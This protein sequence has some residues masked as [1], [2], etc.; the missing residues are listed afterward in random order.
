MGKTNFSNKVHIVHDGDYLK[1]SLPKATNTPPPPK[2]E[3]RSIPST[4]STP[5]PPKPKS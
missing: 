4:P 5:P 2:P 3:E 1:N